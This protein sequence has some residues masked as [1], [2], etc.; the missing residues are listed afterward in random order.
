MKILAK[1]STADS[2]HHVLQPASPSADATTLIHDDLLQS[3]HRTDQQAV[4]LLD[5]GRS[6]NSDLHLA[7]DLVRW[8]NRGEQEYCKH[9]M[10]FA[11]C[12]AG[13]Y[14]QH[15][16][17]P[18]RT[19]EIQ[20]AVSNR[21]MLLP[22]LAAAHLLHF[23]GGMRLQTKET[24]FN[25]LRNAAAS[26]CGGQLDS[27]SST[28]SI[29][30]TSAYGDAVSPPA[31]HQTL[32]QSLSLLVTDSFRHSNEMILFGSLPDCGLSFPETQDFLLLVAQACF[33]T[34]GGRGDGRLPTVID[35]MGRPWASG[36][37]RR[38]NVAHGDLTVKTGENSH[39]FYITAIEAARSKMRL[40]DR[41]ALLA[42][43]RQRQYKCS[44]GP[45][46]AGP[47]TIHHK[48][49]SPLL[50]VIYVVIDV[51]TE[52]ESALLRPS[53][54][55]QE[56]RS[57]HS[58]GSNL[59]MWLTKQ[60]QWL[61]TGLERY[62]QLQ[63]H[64]VDHTP[65]KEVIGTVQRF[66][67]DKDNDE[68][69]KNEPSG[70]SLEAHDAHQRPCVLAHISAQAVQQTTLSNH[71]AAF[72]ITKCEHS[73]T[74][75]HVGHFISDLCST[76]ESV[77]EGGVANS[78]CLRVPD[79][80]GTILGPHCPYIE[81]PRHA[82]CRQLVADALI[83]SMDDCVAF[84]QLGKHPEK[85]EISFEAIEE[86]TSADNDD[87]GATPGLEATAI[88]SNIEV[89]QHRRPDT[90]A[91]WKQQCHRKLSRL[92]TIPSTIA[93]SS[94]LMKQTMAEYSSFSATTAFD[95]PFLRFVALLCQKIHLQPS[96]K[97]KD[98]LPGVAPTRV[99]SMKPPWSSEPAEF[100]R[101]LSLLGL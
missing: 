56:N 22:H 18:A 58:K 78:I 79:I 85:K 35:K 1:D 34:Y 11:L 48:V 74:I 27:G 12:S 69:R 33:S 32:H 84:T 98:I 23:H 65:S 7:A 94:E 57:T 24:L 37:T 31:L 42:R 95:Y 44:D 51:T 71:D 100:I 64:F 53:D 6:S 99:V 50:L 89:Q 62:V 82:L 59:L 97:C 21:Q 46:S 25:Y 29:A 5:N 80:R 61:I 76:L 93:V 72:V 8:S 68:S 43:Q 49:T 41:L 67:R 87:D 55:L 83:S 10:Q 96:E 66:V 101:A 19:G 45:Q 91:Q 52:D 20:L 2:Q 26:G 3:P 28:P 13:N 60:A 14:C 88:S 75:L 39:F 17:D 38:R 30:H 47:Q 81:P 9:V 15:I 86:H 40:I 70:I 4:M 16:G 73:F 92:P 77:Q 36:C 54:D 63:I 90:L